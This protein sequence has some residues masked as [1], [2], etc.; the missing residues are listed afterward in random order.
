MQSTGH[1]GT[2]LASLQQF[3]V[4]TYATG[5]SFQHWRHTLLDR[6]L[7]FSPMVTN[8]IPPTPVR[9]HLVIPK[10]AVP[11]NLTASIANREPVG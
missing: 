5:F 9:D 1:T 11:R 7:I 10:I 6:C 4:I 2:Q 8:D 3:C